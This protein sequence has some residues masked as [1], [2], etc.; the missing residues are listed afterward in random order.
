MQSKEW[1]K[2]IFF[3][4]VCNLCSWAVRFI[5]KHDRKGE[6]KFASLQSHF[7]R[8]FLA[9]IQYQVRGMESV[10]YYRTGRVLSKS[11]AALAI[12]LEFHP[13]WRLL[14]VFWLLPKF[15]RDF[16]YML[17]AKYR[18][19]IFGKKDFCMV[20]D[21]DVSFRFLDQEEA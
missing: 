19:K 17:I 14:W 9:G 8:N 4:G 3:D 12:L 18:Y 16:F 13:L 21:R 2:I 6:L 20:P 7:A 11:S 1:D 15:L 5:L 10:L